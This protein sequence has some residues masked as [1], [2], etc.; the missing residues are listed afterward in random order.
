GL[1]Q[2]DLAATLEAIAQHGPDALYRGPIAS[3]IATASAA[4]GG[5]L[6]AEDFANYRVTEGPLLSCSYRGHRI[7]SAPPPSSGGT[8]I[9]EILNILEGYELKALGFRSAPSVRLLVEAM[10]Y[11]Y[12]DRNTHLGDPAFVHNP[13]GRLLSK[14]YA[15][16]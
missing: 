10:R 13:L 11:A 5:I 15:A 14:D 7:L 8:T 12:R 16:G 4:N 2:A 3:A 9:C 1:A 6:T